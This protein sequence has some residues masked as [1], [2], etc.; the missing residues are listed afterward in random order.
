MFLHF[1]VSFL[2]HYLFYW[3]F[4]IITLLTQYILDTSNIVQLGGLH[5]ISSLWKIY[6]WITKGCIAC[7]VKNSDGSLEAAARSVAFSKH[8]ALVYILCLRQ[9]SFWYLTQSV[10][11]FFVVEKQAPISKP[12]NICLWQATFCCGG[13][14]GFQVTQ[15]KDVSP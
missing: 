13:H 9:T 7:L 5:S 10:D 14:L 1:I 8:E 2:L 6:H 12:H 11:A 3:M 15:K 4:C